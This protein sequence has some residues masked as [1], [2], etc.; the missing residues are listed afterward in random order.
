MAAFAKTIGIVGGAGPMASALLYTSI[1]EIC[2]TQYGAHDYNEFPEIILVSYPFTRG[3]E[4][5]IREDISLCLSKLTNAGASLFCIA[6]NSFHGFL[7]QL[8]KAGFVNLVTTGLQEAARQ[9]ITKALV[10]AAPLTIQL[11]LYETSH[12][13]CIYPSP[14]EQQFVNQLIREIAG[15][16]AREDQVEELR[17][18]IAQ[19]Q[20]RHP[21]DGVILACTELPLLHKKSAFSDTLPVINTIETLARELVMLARIPIDRYNKR[22]ASS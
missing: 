4:S 13:Q 22:E 15:G 8:P 20:A 9:R 3:H 19:I 10:L 18:R 21:F 5:K 17:K 1:L 16:K 6:C 2:Q 11:K 7:P 12:I 14:E